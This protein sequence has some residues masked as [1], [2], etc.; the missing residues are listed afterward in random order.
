H[1]FPTRR[2]SDLRAIWLTAIS[3]SRT[4][5]R[6]DSKSRSSDVR[7]SNGRSSNGQFSVL[8]N[9]LSIFRTLLLVVLTML[10]IVPPLAAQVVSD[11]GTSKIFTAAK[12]DIRI[13]NLKT[14]NS[15]GDDA[16]SFFSASDG[17]IYF[18]SSRA[19]GKY[20]IYVAKRL[21][22]TDANDHSSH[23]RQP[24]GFS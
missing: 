8:E 2:S 15:T 18:T 9:S 20:I 3:N 12:D 13:E 7:S 10:A 21:P 19:D 14:L 16:T 23:W 11:S 24:E 4:M 17:S 1:S 22:P 5:L 6:P